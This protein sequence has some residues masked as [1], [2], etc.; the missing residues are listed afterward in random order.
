VLH[1]TLLKTILTRKD[2]VV[3]NARDQEKDYTVGMYKDVFCKK[4]RIYYVAQV[5]PVKKMEPSKRRSK[6]GSSS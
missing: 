2:N 4:N 3:Y 1:A 6:K 5:K